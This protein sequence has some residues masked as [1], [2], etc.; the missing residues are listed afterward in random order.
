MG[1]NLIVLGLV[2]G[3]TFLQSIF[4]FFSGLINLF[5]VMIS[6]A[7]AFGFYEPLTYWLTAPD[8]MGLSPQYTEPSVLVGLFLITLVALRTAADNLIRGNVHVPQWL[9]W[10]GGTICG[11][12]NAQLTVGTLA[13]GMLMLPIGGKVLGFERY[14]RTAEKDGNN[15]NAKFERNSLWTR[16]DDM[17]AGFVNLLSSKSMQGQTNFASVYPNYVDAVYFS[18]NTVQHESAP[19]PFR[20]RKGG[21][22]FK[23]GLSVESWWEQKTPITDPRYRKDVPGEKNRMPPMTAEKYVPEAGNRLIGMRLQLK[24]AAADRDGGTTHVFRPSMIRLVGDLGSGASARAQQFIP[25]VIGGAD[26]FLS[27]GNRIVDMDN[28]FRI[29]QPDSPLDVWFDVPQEF[30]P[31]FVEYRRHA[32]AEMPEMSKSAPKVALKLMTDEERQAI[33]NNAGRSFFG[34]VIGGDSGDRRDLP[35]EFDL[36]KLKSSPDVKMDGE[37]LVHARVSGTKSVYEKKGAAVAKEFKI[38]AGYKI[39]QIKYVPKQARTVVGEVFNFVGS[40]INQYLAVDDTGTKHPLT[41]YF[42]KV[43]KGNDER[44]EFF[45][46]GPKDEELDP[47]YR[48]MLDFK[49]LEKKDLNDADTSEI[50][51]FFLVKPGTRILRIEN[52]AGDGGEVSLTMGP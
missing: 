39:L 2:A 38:P 5:C 23:D 12:V 40:N 28:N 51:L 42:G 35:Y 43:K 16:C 9:D 8:G 49:D 15:P 26:S 33:A 14:S 52:Q 20:D 34:S 48:L 19:S 36:A 3:V 7:V 27:G 50:Y 45:F 30:V 22:G 41:G 37:L 1:L 4:G 29:S 10:T 11:F 46:N 32:R 21:D 6:V 31:R 47:S 44:F 18:T 25:R 24:K 17:T 13:I